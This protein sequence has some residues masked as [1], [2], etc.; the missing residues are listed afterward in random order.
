MFIF[1]QLVCIYIRTEWQIIANAIRK[2]GRPGNKAAGLTSR[3]R[4]IRDNDIKLSCTLLHELC[5][6]LNMN[7]D[8]WRGKANCCL[9]EVVLAD[10]NY[11]LCVCVWQEGGGG[12][13]VGGGGED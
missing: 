5:P 8:L 11:S 7:F 1:T 12:G 2:Q 9:W 10:F 4:D 3:I 6:I 13:G